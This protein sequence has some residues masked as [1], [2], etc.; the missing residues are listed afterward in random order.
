MSDFVVTL[1]SESPAYSATAH[2][3]IPESLVD[4]MS[5][6]RHALVIAQYAVAQIDPSLPGWPVDDL[7]A[8]ATH[9]IESP[10]PFT[11]AE[12]EMG[13]SFRSWAPK[14][15][16]PQPPSGRTLTRDDL[17]Y[18]RD[19][20]TREP[21]EVERT[22]PAADR[23]IGKRRGRPKGSKNKNSVSLKNKSGRG[24]GRPRGSKNRAK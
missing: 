11:A 19:L 1:E 10:L 15:R 23:L 3:T 20:L 13:V 14:E 12:R 6:L 16:V 4:P 21:I 2:D 5:V 22:H 8:L 7:R 9:L 17:I 24:P 18:L